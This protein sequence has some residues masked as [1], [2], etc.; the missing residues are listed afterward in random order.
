M[1]LLLIIR[2]KRCIFRADSIYCN[3]QQKTLQSFT[4]M[5]CKHGQKEMS[6]GQGEFAYK[7]KRGCPG[8]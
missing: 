2:A 7:A 6:Y 1:N 4:I 5:S 3:H 8:A